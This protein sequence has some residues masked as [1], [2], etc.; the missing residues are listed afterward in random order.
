MTSYTLSVYQFLS[1]SLYLLY[2][3][4]IYSKQVEYTFRKKKYYSS[5]NFTKAND[6][7]YSVLFQHCKMNGGTCVTRID[8]FYIETAI[9]I[10]VGFVWLQW[11][12]PTINR[13]QRLPATAWQINR[14]NR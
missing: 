11:G 14:F 3:N 6:T 4:L 10:V 5:I 2:R 8:G 1:K 12:R 7:F 13:L 9:C